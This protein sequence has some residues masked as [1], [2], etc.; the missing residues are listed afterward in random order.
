[1]TA[2]ALLACT[3]GGAPATPARP[4]E[5]A[6][7]PEAPP[8]PAETLP[9]ARTVRFETEDGVTIVGDL[10]PAAQ[11]DAPAVILLHQLGSDRSEWAPLRERLHAAPSITTLAIDMRGHGESTTSTAGPLEFHT[12]DD[13]TWARTQDDVLAAVRFLTGPDSG[14]TP[15]R[16][17]AVG[18]SIGSTAVIAAAAREPRLATLVALSPGRAYH[19]FDSLTPM[20][21]L[22]DRT[23]LAIVSRDETDGVETAQAMG[24]ITHADATVVD[25]TAHGVAMFSADPATFDQTVA[26]LRSALDRRAADE[27]AHEEPR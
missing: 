1:M 24:R 22:S 16:L 7:E 25:G 26:F 9:A 5:R 8:T 17:A 23:F 19:G 15:A 20:L 27:E 4:S 13:A 10:Q 6:I 2:V 12:F 21:T 3:S 11:P 14:V 18:S